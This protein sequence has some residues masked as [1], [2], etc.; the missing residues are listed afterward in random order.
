MTSL[1]FTETDEELFILQSI[2]DFCPSACAGL[3]HNPLFVHVAG[4]TLPVFLY[5][6][7]V[8]PIPIVTIASPSNVFISAISFPVG[9]GIPDIDYLDWLAWS[10]PICLISKQRLWKSCFSNLETST[11]LTPVRLATRIP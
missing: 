8:T 2:S 9:W 11:N 5:G 1:R 4:I 7:W 6:K 3:V 10:F